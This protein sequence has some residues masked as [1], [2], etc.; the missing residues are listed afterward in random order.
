MPYPDSI[1]YTHCFCLCTVFSF[2]NFF[3]VFFF[4]FFYII[5]D[6]L[7]FDTLPGFRIEFHLLDGGYVGISRSAE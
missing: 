4:S 2:L 6:I 1:Q 5:V 3:F 7:L